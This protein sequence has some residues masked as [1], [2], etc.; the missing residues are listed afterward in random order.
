MDGTLRKVFAQAVVVLL[1]LQVVLPA[2]SQ[3][4]RATTYYV[5]KTADDGSV[6]T[7]RWAIDSANL[8]PGPHSIE[9]DIPVTPADCPDGVCI[10]TPISVLPSVISAGI[11]IDA[12][13]QTANRGNTNI[14]GPEVQ[15]DGSSLGSTAWIFRVESNDNTIKGFAINGA[16]GSGIKIVSGASNNTISDNYIGLLPNGLFADGNG[17]GVEIYDASSDNIVSG[18]LIMGNTGD[19]VWIAGSGTDRNQIQA[20]QIGG[21]SL[22]NGRHGVHILNGPCCTVVG[23]SIAHKNVIIR[24]VMHGVYLTGAGTTDNAVSHNHIGIGWWGLTAAG[25][26]QSGV[27]L[28]DGAAQNS[29]HDNVIS[30]NQGHGVYILGSST[31]ENLLYANI[32]GADAGV[33]KEVPNGLHGVAIYGGAHGNSVGDWGAEIW[34]PSATGALDD[35]G[36]PTGNVIVGSGWSGVAIVGSSQNAVMF[37]RI[38]IDFGGGGSILANAYY[39]VVV[40]GMDNTIGP[41]NTI[42]YNP[43][44]GVLVDGQAYTSQRNLITG[45]SIHSNGGKGIDL[46]NNGNMELNAPTISA[47]SC[48]Q[49]LGSSPCVGCT[50]EI[51]SDRADE[52]SVYQGSTEIHPI[53]LAFEWSGRVLGPNVT[54]TVSDSQGN[55]SEFSSPAVG[56]CYLAFLPYVER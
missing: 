46:R 37:N 26:G 44:D 2:H 6:G 56:A 21:E 54:A 5:S 33:T 36:P 1:L 13:T 45:N 51:F 14:F 41:G 50:A 4:S 43:L 3:T 7:L 35:A 12:T 11:T 32:I 53:S 18:N 52:G 49:V 34:S 42:A 24:N 19:G 25:N 48:A 22:P 55:T 16:G 31:H 8:S 30:G 20:N 29:I 23:G 40:E 28:D 9:F 27:A 39:G 38:G 10:I 47:A 15:V 17:N